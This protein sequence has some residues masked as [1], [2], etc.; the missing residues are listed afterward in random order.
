MFQMRIP[1]GEVPQGG[2]GAVFGRAW[3]RTLK[4]RQMEL[5]QVTRRQTKPQEGN[6]SVP[7]NLPSI[8]NCLGKN[9]ILTFILMRSPLHIVRAD[10][11]E[12]LVSLKK[13]A[14]LKQRL[15]SFIFSPVEE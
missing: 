6:I 9:T 14:S 7:C 3:E 8:D 11:T 1:D 10:K 15:S 12:P 2:G 5:R 13:M 4:S